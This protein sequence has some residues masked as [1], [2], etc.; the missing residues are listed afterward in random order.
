MYRHLNIS[1]L[2]CCIDGGIDFKFSFLHGY[3][4]SIFD[5]VHH[6]SREALDK[7]ISHSLEKPQ[8]AI[9]L[10]GEFDKTNN[11]RRILLKNKK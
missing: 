1:I 4:M 8:N 10:V 11:V 6:P 3:D 2:K 9:N 7:S 5:V